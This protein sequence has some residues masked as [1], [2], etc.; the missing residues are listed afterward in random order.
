[1]KN[2]GS[3]LDPFI[4]E[5][6]SF[7]LYKK[8]KQPLEGVDPKDR[9]KRSIWRDDGI[10]LDLLSKEGFHL[11]KELEGSGIL[12]HEKVMVKEGLFRKRRPHR[13][14]KALLPLDD[15]INKIRPGGKE[16]DPEQLKMLLG[17]ELLYPVVLFRSVENLRESLTGRSITRNVQKEIMDISPRSAVRMLLQTRKVQTGEDD[18]LKLFDRQVEEKHRIKTKSGS[19]ISDLRSLISVILSSTDGELQEL[20]ESGRIMDLARDGFRSPRMEGLFK[21]LSFD[22]RGDPEIPGRFR[23]RLGRAM[24]ESEAAG[25]VF[26]KIAIPLLDRFRSCSQSE[27]SRLRGFLGP[28]M[29]LRASPLLSDLMFS[30]PSK[31]RPFIIDLMGETSDGNLIET[32]KRIEDFSSV[33]EDRI[34]AKNAIERLGGS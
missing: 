4:K 18:L 26:S 30:V 24:M 21:D 34:A 1:M 33:E 20:M 10:D 15:L 32:L 8:G 16:M 27:A 17:S 2:E 13:I 25:E 14:M 5:M 31:N 9:I 7:H 3:P 19:I 22:E 29:G 12:I 23:I 28:L 6:L 11:S